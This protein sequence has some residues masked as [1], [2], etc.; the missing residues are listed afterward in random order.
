M[1]QFFGEYYLW[2]KAVHIVFV[3]SW[4]AGLLYLPRLFVYHTRAAPGSQMDDTFKIMERRLLRVIIN[5]AGLIVLV[6]GL[7][8]IVV[9]R[10]G[11]PGSGY[12]MHAKLLLVLGLAGLHGAMALFRKKFAQ[13]QN[14]KS[15]NFYRAFNE[16]PTLLMILIV[17][18]VVLKPF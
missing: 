12:W 10:A 15:E 13:G 2:L 6:T 16:I 5:P 3:I 7:L 8:L 4:M 17:L 14:Q 9:T 18:L 1:S 11:A